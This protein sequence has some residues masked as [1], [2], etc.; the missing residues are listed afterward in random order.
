VFD[1]YWLGNGDRLWERASISS[2]QSPNRAQQSPQQPVM[3]HQHQCKPRAPV[4]PQRHWYSSSPR[5]IPVLPQTTDL[6]IEQ[7]L[8]EGDVVKGQVIAVLDNSVLQAQINEARADVESNQ[9]V[10]GRKAA[11]AQP[12]YL[13][14]SS[15]K[16][17][18]L[19]ATADAG[20]ISRRSRYSY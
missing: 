8:D 20:A 5:S 10:V 16:S 2:N 12:C 15:T 11:P 6:Q 1:R 17:T 9:A 18:A 19:P 4:F 7:L 13:S 3:C 14:R